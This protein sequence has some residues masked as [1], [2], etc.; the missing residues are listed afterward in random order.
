MKQLV[1]ILEREGCS[2][3]IRSQGQER[4]YWQRGVAD[5]LRLLQHDPEV[6]HD[7][8]LADK[9]VGKGADCIQCGSCMGHCP[10]AIQIPD[11]MGKITEMQNSL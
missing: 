10:Q 4:C 5:L 1:T 3:V 11:L 2:I 6:L 8:Q 7:A 9:V